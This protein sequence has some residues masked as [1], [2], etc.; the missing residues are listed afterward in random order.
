MTQPQYQVDDER[1]LYLT[2][3]SSNLEKLY[4]GCRWAEGPVWFNDLGCSGVAR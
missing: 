3:G 1:F 4:G 2:V